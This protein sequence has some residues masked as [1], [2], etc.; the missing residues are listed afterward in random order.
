LQYTTNIG[1]GGIPSGPWSNLYVAPNY[2]FENHYVIYD[3]FVP[4]ERQRFY[5]LHAFKSP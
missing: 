5:R 2:P 1:V 3:A 4:T